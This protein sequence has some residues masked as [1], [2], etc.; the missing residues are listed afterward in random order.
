MKHCRHLVFVLGDQLDEQSP[1][2]ADF[3]PAT[4]I[5]LMAEVTDES[6]HVWSSKPRTAFFFAA[7]RHFA[8]A[9]EQRDINVDYRRIGTHAC[10]SLVA[11][12][13]DAVTKYN[14]QKIVMT[15]PG[16]WRVE[17]ALTA[18]GKTI[19][20]G[21]VFREDTHFLCSRHEFSDWAKGYKQPRLEFFYRM[22]RKRHSVMMDGEEP[23]Q[24]R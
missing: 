12:L 18:F 17:Q 24:G 7:M 21:L 1:A 20:A 13:A 19:S 16:D 2:L 14:P 10:A 4:D 6:T 8:A 15:E 22:M 11:V 3:D 9:L 5:V 23:L